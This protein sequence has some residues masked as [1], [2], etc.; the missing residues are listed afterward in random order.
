MPRLGMPER[1]CLS[2]QER[3]ACHTGSARLRTGPHA[4]GR[5][6]AISGERRLVPDLAS[7]AALDAVQ[8]P[9]IAASRCSDAF[10]VLS[11]KFAQVRVESA[12]F[13]KIHCQQERS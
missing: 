12:R 11:P 9:P 13:Q 8:D 5:V 2:L 7:V 10:G 1:W 6:E 3:L 4:P